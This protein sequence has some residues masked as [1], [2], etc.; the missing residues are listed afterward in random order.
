VLVQDAGG[1]GRLVDADDA[2]AA[3]SPSGEPIARASG[4]P[5]SRSASLCSTPS[6][7]RCCASKPAPARWPKA[8]QDAPIR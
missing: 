3:P 4:K 7:Q 6:S 2:A 5:T 8:A 1:T